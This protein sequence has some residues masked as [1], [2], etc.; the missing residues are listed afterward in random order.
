[1]DLKNCKSRLYN[2]WFYQITQPFAKDERLLKNH[3]SYC[4]HFERN[5]CVD[6]SG[7]DVKIKTK[8]FW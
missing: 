7:V 3:F 5:I 6:V 8:D 4:F 2:L 1:M